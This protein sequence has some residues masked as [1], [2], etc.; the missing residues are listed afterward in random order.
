MEKTKRSSLRKIVENTILVCISL[1]VGLVMAEGVLRVI[2]P[3]LKDIVYSKFQHDRYRI[4]VN[5]RSQRYTRLHPDTKK[6]HVVI[7]NSLGMRQHREFSRQKDEDTVR[8]GFFGDSFTENLRLPVEYS[9]TE[10]L[11]YLL[12]RSGKTYEVLNFGTDGYGT[13]QAYLQYV[14]ESGG[15]GLNAAA[16]VYCHNDLTDILADSLFEIDEQ[17][18]LSYVPVKPPGVIKSVARKTYLTYFM[19]E[20]LSVLNIHKTE[21]LV[22]DEIDQDKLTTYEAES[23]NRKQYENLEEAFDKGQY[24]QNLRKSLAIFKAILTEWKKEADSRSQIF[25][26]VLLPRFKEANEKI[27][28]I[29]EELGIEVLNLYPLFENEQPELTRFYFKNDGHWNEEGN[30]IA[31]V[32][33]FKYLAQ[34]FGIPYGE[35]EFIKQGLYEFYSSF[36]PAAV[37]GEWLG[38]GPVDEKLKHDIRSSYLNLD[39]EIR[40]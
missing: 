1:F 17:G 20:A 36:E 6:E 15:L 39:P 40:K 22:L 27:K 33:I 30:K 29:I 14:D 18:Y 25:F 38:A 19:I 23:V 7:H 37:S 32:Y 10:S 11:D 2:R 34:R 9:F 26:V 12:N 31:T 5:P 24:S 8:I 13:D 3:D 35:D 21:K 16:Y 28:T 4:H